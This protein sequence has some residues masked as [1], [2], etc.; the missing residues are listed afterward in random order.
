MTGDVMAP[1]P[2]GPPPTRT[3]R[4]AFLDVLRAVAVCL[5]IYCH[6]VG[7]WLHQHGENSI[8]AGLLQGYATRPL[9]VALNVGNFGVVLFF[10]VSGF[11]VTHTGLT[12]RPRQYLAK[13]FLRIYPMLAVS[14]LLSAALL[15]LHLHPLATGPA[16]TTVTP[17]TLL[18]NA[19][20]ANY[21]LS[22]P[23]VLID[24]AWSLVIEITFYALLLAVLPLLRRLGW[25]VITAE[26]GLVAA[27]LAT[28]HLG[29]TGY[30][31]F[32]GNVGYL[33]ALLL[34]QVIWAVWSRR[35]PLP[36]GITLGALAFAEYTWAG[37]PGLGRQQTVY[38][39]DINLALGFVTFLLALLAERRLR[40]VRWIGFIADRSY[41]LY[42]LHGLLG[43]IT[44][45]ALAPLIG[46]PGALAA[47]IAT[48]GLGADLTHRFVERP[49]MRAARRWGAATP[50]AAALT[51]A[52]RP[53]PPT[54][55]Q[56]SPE[57][58]NPTAASPFPSTP[59]TPPAART[60]P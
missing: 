31:L 1:P 56:D 4:F 40:P 5:V 14:V 58:S 60:T 50:P 46:Y 13:R 23:V 53:Y 36:V 32:A 20:L 45:N 33:P 41:S 26:L 27:V 28:A 29:G 35:A 9:N 55:D 19:S 12:E 57:P 22:P 3:G 16:T 37:T 38:H 48:T 21:L 43:V 51:P 8:A 44:L 34:G 17:L 52:R 6:L 7:V 30:F 18:T 54:S 10:L 24:V 47:G 25:T 15:R 49:S 42:L 39:Y 2:P 11:I 59:P